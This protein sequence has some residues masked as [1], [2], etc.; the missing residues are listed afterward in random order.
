M[1]LMRRCCIHMGL[2]CICSILQWRCWILLGSFDLAMTF[3]FMY[4]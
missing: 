4:R 3:S 2:V 1:F